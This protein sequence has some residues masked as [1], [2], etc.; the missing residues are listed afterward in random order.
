MDNGEWQDWLEEELDRLA[1]EEEA[2]EADEADEAE[3][4]AW[5]IAQMER[6]MSAYFE[7]VL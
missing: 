6:R 2:D 7:N 1:H 5:A 3:E 4:E